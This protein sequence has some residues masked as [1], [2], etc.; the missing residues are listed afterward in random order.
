MENVKKPF[1]KKW[2]FWV[3][4]VIVVLGISASLEDSSSKKTV[5]RVEAKAGKDSGTDTK[6]MDSSA[7]E[8]ASSEE[9][10]PTEGMDYAT[11]NAFRSAVSYLEYTGFSKAGLIDQL[12]SEYGDNYTVQQ[13]TDA[14]LALEAAGLVD[15]KEQAV[16]SGQSYLE[17]SS[18]SRKGLIDQLSSPYGGKFTVAQA[19]YAADQLGLR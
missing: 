11:K 8:D 14:V 15:W 10:D 1:Y 7:E 2:W 18:F 12:S 16:R 9:P 4:A 5:D 17:Y 3:L 19:T 6:S 13:A